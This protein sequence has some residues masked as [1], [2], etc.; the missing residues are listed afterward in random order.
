MVTFIIEM[1]S[2]RFERKMKRSEL[3]FISV[4]ILLGIYWILI[5]FIPDIL[6]PISIIFESL[7]EFSILIGY[8]GAFLVSLLGNATILVP[9]PYIA[10]PFFL[11]ISLFNPW[12]TGLLAGLGAMLGEMTGYYAGYIGQRYMD[13]EK[14]Q[15]FAIYLEEQRRR[16][17]LL[18]WFLAATPIPDDFLIVPLG[19][20][21]YPWWK[22][23]I[24]G[25]IGKTVFLTGIAW[26][27]NLGIVWIEQ[28]LGNSTSFV[29]RSIEVIALF[30]IAIFIFLLTKIDWKSAAEKKVSSI[31][32]SSDSAS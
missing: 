24:P 13:H 28:L 21:K 4:C 20:A 32:Y 26:A 5:F 11:G 1:N 22:V 17:P 15:N 25:F 18:V 7:K 27:G 16:I 8:P 19:T 30:L 29:S 12:I 2:N 31:D 6:N 9:F 23:F 14:T 3:V 10:V